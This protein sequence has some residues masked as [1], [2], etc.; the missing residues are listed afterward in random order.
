MKKP[1]SV[2]E[3]VVNSIYIKLDIE[4]NNLFI[5][6][7]I[8]RENDTFD[9]VIKSLSKGTIGSEVKIAIKNYIKYATKKPYPDED[10]DKFFKQLKKSIKKY[11]VRINRYKIQKGL[12][13]IRKGDV[14][15]D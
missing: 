12:P 3:F 1:E 14:W 10:M 13:K 11:F 6:S 2:H 4:K 7:M 9:K 8:N 15:Y 5:F